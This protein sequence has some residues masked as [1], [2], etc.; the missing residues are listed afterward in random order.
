MAFRPSVL[1][2]IAV[3]GCSKGRL[4]TEGVCELPLSGACETAGGCPSYPVAVSG[5]RG[6]QS[7]W[8]HIETGTCDRGHYT[9]RSAWYMTRV[10]YFDPSGKML[11]ASESVDNVSQFC[12]GRSGRA[13]YGT[14]PK[15]TPTPTEVIW[16]GGAR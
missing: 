4:T 11:G 2:L 7:T 16:D 3:L 5:L 9:R 12:D 14:L 13:L 8:S 6:G 10:D 1:V 15:C